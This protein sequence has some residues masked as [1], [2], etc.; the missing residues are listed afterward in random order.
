MALVFSCPCGFRLQTDD[1]FANR[2]VRCPKC[3]AVLIVPP[4]SN[5]LATVAV[6]APAPP[7]QV[8][9]VAPQPRPSPSPQARDEASHRREHVEPVAAGPTGTN[10]KAIFAL[11]LGIVA[12][13]GSSSAAGSL[14]S[15]WALSGFGTFCS[16]FVFGVPAIIL[17]LQSAGAIKRSNGQL[18]GTGMAYTGVGLGAAGCIFSLLCCTCGGFYGGTA[19]IGESAKRMSSKNNL[20]QI[21]LAMANYHSAYRALPTGAIYSQEGKPLLSWRVAILPFVEQENLYNQFHLDEPWDSPNNKPLLA[22]M[23]KI[24]AAPGIEGKADQTYYRV[25]HLKDPSGTATEDRP[26][27]VGTQGLTLS[28]ITNGRGAS[29][30]ILVVEAADSVPWTKPD[31]LSYPVSGAVEPLLGGIFKDGYHVAF[32]DGSVRFYTK[33]HL[34]DTQLKAAITYTNETMLPD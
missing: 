23:P 11:I 33:G 32:A 26:P 27:F 24:Y 21:G 7:V 13:C 22:T 31:E 8:Q 18:A 6:P 17:G 30:T 29:N 34:T 15:S 4:T 2:Q 14:M 1:Q 16:V 9:P 10:N 12:L 5:M 28:I 3:S 20:M 19:S 25:F